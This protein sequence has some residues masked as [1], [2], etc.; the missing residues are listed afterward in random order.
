MSVRPIPARDL[1][2]IF[3]DVRAMPSARAATPS[4]LSRFASSCL[5]RIAIAAFCALYFAWEFVR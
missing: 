5:H 2:K 3:A 4:G 1:E